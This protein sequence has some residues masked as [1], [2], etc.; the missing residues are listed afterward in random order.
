MERC[1]A[2]VSVPV[3]SDF[4][5]CRM[6]VRVVPVFEE[7]VRSHNRAVGERCEETQNCDRRKNVPGIPH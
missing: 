2:V 5:G 1:N 6:T 7:Q 3:E 4:Q